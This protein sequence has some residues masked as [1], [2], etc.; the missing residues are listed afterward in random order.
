MK[1]HEIILNDFLN[2]I[3]CEAIT[4]ILDVGSGRTSLSML[5]FGYLLK[6]G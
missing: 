4:N 3:K 5:T 2:V 1:G 6:R